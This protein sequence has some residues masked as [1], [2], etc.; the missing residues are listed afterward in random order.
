VRVFALALAY[1]LLT[2]YFLLSILLADHALLG[3]VLCCSVYALLGAVNSGSGLAAAARRGS[4]IDWLVYRNVR[5]S[6]QIR[7]SSA[8]T[9]ELYTW[10]DDRSIAYPITS[11]RWRA[12]HKSGYAK[13][14]ALALRAS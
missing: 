10:A 6:I 2:S 13:V 12:I 4:T 5:R 9:R 11:W 8:Q 7:S 1:L 14:G 3:E